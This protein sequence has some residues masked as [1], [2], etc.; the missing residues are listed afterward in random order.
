MKLDGTL[1]EEEQIIHDN[2]KSYCE[3][4]VLPYQENWSRSR[5]FPRSLMKGISDIA[6]PATIP[7]Q[8]GGAGI[9]ETSVGIFSELM[10]RYEFPVPAF[11]TMHFAKLLPLI[12]D[13]KIREHYLKRYLSGELVVCGAFTEPG[14]GS[15]AAAIR[16]EAMRDGDEFIISGE[17]AF[18]SSPG[19]ADVHIVSARTAGTVSSSPHKGVSLI[20]LD[21]TYSGIEPYEMESM[22]SVF[23]GDFGGIRMDSVR[24]P[25]GNMIGNENSGF[26]TL[27]QIL[28]VQRVH[29]ALYSIGLAEISLEEAI[30][31]A[32]IRNTFGKPLSKNQA[33]S[34]RLAEDWG[35]LEAAKLLAYKALSMQE[36]GADNSAECATVKWLGCETAF[37]AVSHSLQ[38]LGAA[39]YVKTSPME[40]RFRA[41]RGFL[42]GDGTPDI[43]KLIVSRKLFGKE[44]A[45]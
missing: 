8:S 33:V 36:K 25:E 40:R 32:K 11:L 19:N 27:M 28:N 6:L 4:Y 24:V 22:A 35:R 38:T 5:E 14:A 45:P 30:E 29:V 2:F 3:K 17:K 20:L 23:R 42:I 43:Q 7:E 21:S 39:G 12:S 26:A 34:F 10:G 15:D 31:Y 37:E 41:A 13:N 18:V 16:T 1:N 9:P 44:Y